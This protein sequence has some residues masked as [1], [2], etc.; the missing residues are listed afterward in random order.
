MMRRN[1]VLGDFIPDDEMPAPDDSATYNL[2]KE[3]I[4][5]VLD[6]LPP[7]EVRILQL[8]YGL[9]DGQSYTLEEVGRKMGV[10]RE[11]VTPDRGAGLEPTTASDGP[12]EAAGVSWRIERGREG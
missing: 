2:L 9:V 1:S 6:G 3:H 8:R 7:R 4:Y 10:T 12:A 11:R 5:T